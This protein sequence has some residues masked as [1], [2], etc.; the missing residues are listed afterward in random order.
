MRN[1]FPYDFKHADLLR[2]DQMEGHLR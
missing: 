2:E 1:L